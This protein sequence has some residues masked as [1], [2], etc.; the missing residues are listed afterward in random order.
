MPFGRHKG[1]RLEHI[2]DSYLLWLLDDCKDLS[3]TLRRAVL[4]QLGLDEEP[5]PDWPELLRQWQRQMSLDYH[6]DRGGSV[7]AMQAVNDGYERLLELLERH[8]G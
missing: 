6:P 7:E 5:H 8:S 2:P 3:P 1:Q 4:A